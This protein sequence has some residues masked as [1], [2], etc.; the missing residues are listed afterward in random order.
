M[1]GA[2]VRFARLL[3]VSRV[4]IAA[5]FDEQLS[6]ALFGNRCSGAAALH[7]WLGAPVSRSVLLRQHEP[8][9]RRGDV[10][11]AMD[12]KA[13]R[14]EEWLKHPPGVALE[15]ALISQLS[16]PDCQALQDVIGQR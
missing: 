1:R 10:H 13:A 4:M 5:C 11:A 16:R 2:V 7:A 6:C 14:C 3:I 12:V 15:A 9:V 8:A